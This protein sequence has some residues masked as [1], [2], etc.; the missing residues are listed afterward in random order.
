M[1]VVDLV[2]Y[3]ISLCEL[4]D[5]IHPYVFL[6]VYVNLCC[7]NKKKRNMFQFM[8]CSEVNLKK[9]NAN[10]LMEES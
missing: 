1:Q 4:D 5:G 9:K 7:G 10:S 3:Q 6:L 2:S 8:E